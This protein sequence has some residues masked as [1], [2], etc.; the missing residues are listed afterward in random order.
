MLSMV[1]PAV[2]MPPVARDV[3][4]P[5]PGPGE[6]LVRIDACGVC[7]SDLFLQ[8]GGFGPGVLP[9]VPGHEAS[10]RV[11]AVGDGD[12]AGWVG[13]QVALY[14]IACPPGSVWAARGMENVDPGVKRMGVDVDG[15]FA[16]H[17][18]RPVATLVAVDPEMDPV[19]VAVSTDALATPYHA[20]VS[21]ARVRPGER[22]VVIGLGGIGSNAVQ[23]AAMAGADVTAVGR[24]EAKRRLALDLG[25]RVAVASADGVDAVVEACGGPPDVVV[26]CVGEDPGMD[27]FAVD[28]AGPAARVVMVGACREPFPVSSTDLIW[29]ELS[30]SGSRGHTRAEIAAVLDLVRGGALRTDH[31]TGTV[32]PLTEAAEAMDDLR[33]GRVMRTVLVPEQREGDR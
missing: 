5:T 23:I 21:K 1:L 13:R 9:V 7:G 15:A 31:L 26:Q 16:E 27:R 28:V 10:G 11:V 6:A 22:V 33:N 30:V 4:T 2:G 19:S 24:G 14:Y 29:R 25:A 18:V 8:D 3:A 32:R 17:V 20:V 12:D